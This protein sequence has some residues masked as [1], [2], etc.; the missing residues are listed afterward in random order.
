MEGRGNRMKKEDRQEL[1]SLFRK[2]E[3]VITQNFNDIRALEK[4]VKRLKK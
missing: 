1:H 3:S 2:V 4:K